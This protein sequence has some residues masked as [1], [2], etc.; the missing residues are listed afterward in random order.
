MAC[1]DGESQLGHI[2]LIKQLNA[3]VVYRLID[4]HGPISRI[5]LSR[6]AQL[7]P[8][9]ITKIVREMVDA[10]L[11][12]EF[13]STEPGSRGRPA[14]GLKIETKTWH[15]LSLH[16]SQGQLTLGLRDLSSQCIVEDIVTFLP[17]DSPSFLNDLFAAIDAFFV[18]HHHKIER[19]TAI[20]MTVPGI[21]DAAR[22]IIQQITGYS[23]HNL[24]IVKILANRIGVAVF[25]QQDISAW[26]LAETLLGAAN[27]CSDV[28][29]LTLDTHVQVGIITG[30]KLLHAG[31][32]TLPEIGHF[33]VQTSG[34]ACACGRQGCLETTTN[35][36]HIL[37]LAQRRLAGEQEKPMT[38]KALCTLALN[39]EPQ[40]QAILQEVAE[41]IGRALALLVN[42]FNPDK[43]L[44][45]SPL[46][47]AGA[48]FYPQILNIIQAQTLP[49]Y[50]QH[51]I[52]EST[53]FNLPSTI[54]GAGLIKDALY[55]GSLLIK[56]LQ[57]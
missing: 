12:Q 5:D 10:Q 11:L 15:F 48:V 1:I 20:T 36:T 46:S 38:I 17:S 47:Q 31:S 55:N 42:I 44:I 6:L 35:L 13:E 54:A 30:G 34:E 18:R 19:L 25:V 56:L 3:G 14:V 28:I 33:H 27:N 43:I 26:V 57:G 52:I 50:S 32:R 49:R 4:K 9:S 24:P 21:V 45:G 2:D 7:A 53:Q 39:G 16:I 22:G 51:L 40:A 41:H 29:Q 23:V 37:A 8:A